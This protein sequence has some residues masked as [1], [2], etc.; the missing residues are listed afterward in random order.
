MAFYRA[1]VLVCGGAGCISSGC[2]A[3][4]QAL[5]DEIN[6][7]GISEEIKVIEMCIR[8]RDY[9]YPRH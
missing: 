3:V 9:L 7:A 2:K 8:D 1:Q 6:K 4:Q 5:I